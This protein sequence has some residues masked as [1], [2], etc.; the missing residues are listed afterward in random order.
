M[1]P[2]LLLNLRLRGLV[3]LGL[4]KWAFLRLRRSVLRALASLGLG[5]LVLL[6]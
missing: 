1:S 2:Q 4:R 5:R 6:C 3:L